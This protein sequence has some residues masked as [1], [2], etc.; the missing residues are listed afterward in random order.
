MISDDSGANGPA[1]LP[2]DLVSARA[3]LM[4][5]IIRAI[6]A[7]KAKLEKKVGACLII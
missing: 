2:S 3:R 7:G 5:T 4:I 1:F 6:K